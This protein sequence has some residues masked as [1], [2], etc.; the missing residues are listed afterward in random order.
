MS[1]GPPR[2]TR[3][4]LTNVTPKNV[5][6]RLPK[7]GP[8]QQA[9]EAGEIDAIIDYPG[10]NVILLP[11]ARRALREAA[12]RTSA[13]NREAS[14]ANS[15]LAALPHADYQHLVAS[16]EPLT[17]RFGE[18]LQEPGVP[19]RYVYFPVDCAISLL[20]TVE[21]AR[22][23]E[24]GLV[25]REGMIGISFALG[26]DVSSVRALVQVTGTAVRMKAAR[27][28]EALRQ[29][30]SLQRE[31]YHYA[32]AKLA[33][34]RQIVACN[35]FHSVEARLARW[36]LTISDRVLSAE[37]FLT[38]VFLAQMLGV[39]RGTVNAAA[40]PLR[41]RK[42]I[43]YSRGKIRILD[44]KGLEAAACPCYARIEVCRRLRE[45]ALAAWSV[46]QNA[47]GQTGSRRSVSLF[48]TS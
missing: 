38:Q 26:I 7:G 1:P 27:F 32:D 12:K 16:L 8:E 9:V 2:R 33:L 36:L 19:I 43:G 29:C 21:G 5:L 31:L 15:L 3:T 28:R 34:A 23:L 25:G 48:T 42:L 35:C 6:L 30:P 18:V 44:R 11:A 40:G 22:A 4:R 17:L 20:A 39:R 13:A 47:E 41:Q 24:V 37:F 46:Q 14:V 10:G 45:Q